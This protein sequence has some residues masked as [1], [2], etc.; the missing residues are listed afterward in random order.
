MN[1]RFFEHKGSDV[2]G[3]LRTH[4]DNEFLFMG[5]LREP[6]RLPFTSLFT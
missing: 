3:P 1:K 5:V 6:L 4:V 2:Y